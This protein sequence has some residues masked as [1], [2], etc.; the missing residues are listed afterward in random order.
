MKRQKPIYLKTKFRLLF[1]KPKYNCPNFANF[2]AIDGRVERILCMTASGL[3]DTVMIAPAISALKEIFPDASLT[4]LGHSKYGTSQVCELIPAVDGTIDAGLE[5]YSWTA[6][7]RF[8]LYQF[9]K[10][11]LQLRERQSDLVVVF[12]PNIVRKLLLVSIRSRYWI[13]SN[14]I[15]SYPG[16]LALELVECI[17]FMKRKKNV[18]ISD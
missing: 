14:R 11:V 6:V 9:W 5:S 10:L 4:F 15:D 1:L 12:M 16:T 18:S 8:M 7:F 17:R 3:G 13:Y 2:G